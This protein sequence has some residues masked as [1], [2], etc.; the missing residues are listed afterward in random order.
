LQEGKDLFPQVKELESALAKVFSESRRLGTVNESGF[1]R[2]T[3]APH[4]R[5]KF[6]FSSDYFPNLSEN[7]SKGLSFCIYVA[8]AQ[9]RPELHTLIRRLFPSNREYDDDVAIVQLKKFSTLYKQG[10]ELLWKHWRW[11]V[12]LETV[13]GYRSPESAPSLIDEAREWVQG[14]IKYNEEMTQS[15]ARRWAK[16][17]TLLPAN[18]KR[19]EPLTLRQF[20]QDPTRYATMG[21]GRGLPRMEARVRQWGK[22][23]W[24]EEDVKLK[25]SKWAGY[26][27]SDVDALE[28]L[29]RKRE[30]QHNWMFIKPDEP[31]KIRSI[32]VGDQSTYLKMSFL[33]YF[34]QAALSGAE[35]LPLMWG[36][37]QRRENIVQFARR[38]ANR[39]LVKVPVDQSGFD[40]RVAL[41]LVLDVVSWLVDLA[42]RFGAGDDGIE[43]GEAL[44]YSL[45][46]GVLEADGVEVPIERG[47]LSGWKWTALIDSLA[48]FVQF[49]EIREAMGIPT[50]LI[51]TS[52]FFGDDVDAA[53]R[54][55]ESAVA[56][57]RG[58]TAYG[59]DVNPSKSWI[60]RT[61]DEF[62]RKVA[63]NGDVRGYPARTVTGILYQRP[64][65]RPPQ[66][67]QRVQ[68]QVESW[69]KLVSRGADESRVLGLMRAEIA[70]IF[71]LSDSDAWDLLHSP[72]AV[73]GLG[74]T[75]YGSRWLG[76][77]PTGP[78]TSKPGFISAKVP[79][80][81]GLEAS[82]D[83]LNSVLDTV[84][85]SQLE[86]PPMRV[87]E[88]EVRKL[89]D[90]M[91]WAPRMLPTCMPLDGIYWNAPPRPRWRSWNNVYNMVVRERARASWRSVLTEVRNQTEV[92]KARS[93]LGS[94]CWLDWLRGSLESAPVS[95]W[96]ET[97]AGAVAKS[98][99]G[100]VWDRIK[101]WGVNR[102]RLYVEIS[103][104]AILAEQSRYLGS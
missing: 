88:Y 103:T 40:F 92:A 23:G 11:C 104:Q 61:R 91:R 86:E 13:G 60:S 35:K 70:R 22:D 10:G 64:G 38:A 94:R 37:K 51:D 62:L 3:G 63:E 55:E 102:W 19:P 83:E 2:P 18:A 74:V 16:L 1:G 50:T 93:D 99:A 15:R 89:N 27:A 80:L 77:R 81:R 79:L 52:W 96:D 68:E 46:G 25:S 45:D 87:R 41:I 12:S 95:G 58:Y 76:I 14:E 6:R 21:S 31:A 5:A 43:L 24:T 101:R 17:D 69:A 20:L 53:T 36:D 28:R 56:L 73:G 82:E 48:N 57:L 30:K 34:V 67:S 29:A 26:L 4:N 7:F 33:D 54:T 98:Q 85:S 44:L 59:L 8:P 75:P 47:V 9:V 65:S 84:L 90:G 71:N 100:R 78:A 72:R 32:V 66:A 39:L 49:E 42:V 97:I